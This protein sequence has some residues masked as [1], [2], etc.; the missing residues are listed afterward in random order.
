MK[1]LLPEKFFALFVTALVLPFSPALAETDN[2]NW[3]TVE[4]LSFTRAKTAQVQERWPSS[5]VVENGIDTSGFTPIPTKQ[6]DSLPML[7]IEP[8]AAAEKQLGRHAYAINR[9]SGLSVKSHQVWRQKGLPRDQAS[10]INLESDSPA[11]NGKVRISLSRYL[12]ADFDIQL[13]NPDWSPSF[14]NPDALQQETVAKTILFNVSRKLKRDK[15]HYIDHPLAGILLY[16]ERYKKE[17][18]LPESEEADS[19]ISQPV[20][21]KSTT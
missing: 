17:T 21:E 13:Q 11:L 16:I 14:S 12:H 19:P 6:P 4:V 15:L 3:Y 20:K 9:A 2:T 1:K 5:I 18:V 10:W 7:D 8:V